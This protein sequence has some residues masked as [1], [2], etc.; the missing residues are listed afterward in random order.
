VNFTGDAWEN[1]AQF[2]V[3][4]I[5][6]C[7]CEVAAEVSAVP[8]LLTVFWVNLKNSLNEGFIK[9]FTFTNR[10]TYLLVLESTKIYIKIRTKMLLHV[11]VYDHHQGARTG[12]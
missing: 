1:D 12:A 10:C 6:T 7:T 9:C 3:D 8:E 11:S 5:I 4:E 2:L